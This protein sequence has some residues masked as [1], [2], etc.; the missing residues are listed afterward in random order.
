M[1]TDRDPTVRLIF[2]FVSVCRPH[3]SNVRAD[4]FW[5]FDCGDARE[6]RTGLYNGTPVN[7]PSYSS[8]D[9]SGQGQALTLDQNRQQYIRLP[10]SLN[11][12]LNTS[13]TLSLWMYRT[14][15]NLKAILTDC[16]ALAKI[17]VTFMVADTNLYLGLLN[18]TTGV[19]VDYRSVSTANITC[20]SCWIYLTFAFNRPNQRMTLYHD[21]VRLNEFT[22]QFNR[23][24][25]SSHQTDHGYAY[26]GLDSTPMPHSF[27]GLI[28]QLALAYYTKNDSEILDEA[29]LLCSYT[30]EHENVSIDSGPLNIPANSNSVYR[31]SSNNR[32]S[33]LINS[34]T[35]YFQFAGMTVL[36]SNRYEYSISFWLRVSFGTYD[37]PNTALA[38]LQFTSK[39]NQIATADYQCIATL[40]IDVKN[41]TLA[42]FIPGLYR[43]LRV[44]NYMFE[45]NTWVHIGIS[46]QDTDFIR[47]YID[48]ELQG[49]FMDSRFSMLLS[50]NPRIAITFGA[51]YLK[52][53]DFTK[54]DNYPSMK[55]FA[56]I[57]IFNYTQMNGEIDDV[58]F[59]SRRLTDSEFALF[60]TDRASSRLI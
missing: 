17:C 41:R 10:K 40:H 26:I 14:G 33:L 25:S 38:I 7:G 56:E 47:I 29:T 50:E 51:I 16:S 39:V 43:V 5:S 15:F 46:Y 36:R 44:N 32:S 24:A 13:F 21:G 58:Q 45:N 3:Q 31:R 37:R 18:I 8:P 35:S 2:C 30:F 57:P 55:C 19:P 28:D 52:N 9:F 48:G 12:T 60:A 23:S 27:N 4:Y 42:Y 59:F 54:S 6:D 1:S 20:Q 22:I 11:L 34:T 49:S 53:T